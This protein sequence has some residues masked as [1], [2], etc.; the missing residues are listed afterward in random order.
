MGEPK[1]PNLVK[2]L[3]SK[4][5]IRLIPDIAIESGDRTVNCE[6]EFDVTVINESKKFASFCIEVLAIGADP[7]SNVKWYSLEPEVSAKKPPGDRTTFHVI[8]TKP[9]IP[10]YD[11]TIEL[12]LRVFSVEYPQVFTSQRINLIV[13]KARK[14]LKLHL[15]IQEFKVLPGEEVEIPVI[16]YNLSQKAT[17]VQLNI[18]GLDPEWIYRGTEQRLQIDAGDYQ[19]TSFWCQPQK[20]TQALSQAYNFTIEAKSDTSTRNPRE[21]GILEL[22]PL[23]NV[24][25][26]CKQ[27]LQRI[28]AIKV[29]GA[30]KQPKFATYE[31]EF[32]NN[33]NLPQQVNLQISAKDVQQCGLKIPEPLQLEPGEIKP[34]Y[35]VAKKRRPWW[36]LERRLLF[37][38]SPILTNPYT[39]EPDPQIRSNP[40]T[41]VLE[42]QI[43]PIIPFWLQLL[44][45]LLLLLLLW[46]LWYLNPQDYHKGSVHSVRLIGNSSLVVSGSSDQTIR[47]WQVDRSPWKLD[48]RRLKYE[49][50]IAK[51]TGKAVRVIHQSPRE[52]YVIASALE[53]GD[54][55][56]WDV[57]SKTD[58]R[59]IYQGTD[60][61][62]ALTFSKDSNYLFS[63]HGSGVV[64]GWNLEKP[65]NIKP[66]IARTGFTVYAMSISENL[67]NQ[68][69]TLVAIAGRYNKLS[70]WDWFNRRIYELEYFWEDGKEERKFSPIIGQHQYIDSLTIADPQSLMASSDNEGHISLWDMDKIRQC[71]NKSVTIFKN[72]DRSQPKTDG[73]GNLVIP[74]DCDDAIIDRWHQGHD[75]QPVRAVALS[76]NG[77]YLA[78][79]GDDGRVILWPLENRKRSPQY[80]DGKI[81]AEFPGV[82]L[83]SV[84]IKA[85]DDN[86]FIATG[87]DRNRVRLYRVQGI[88]ENDNANCQ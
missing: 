58:T 82:R 23:G 20:T 62:F 29:K 69:I 71:I 4:R 7:E 48:R 13:E 78:S 66:R 19:Q 57:L 44:G 45:L 28:P 8:I 80:P 22:L 24:E 81:I 32:A 63:G 49:G 64:R 74:L 26:M 31:L 46:L 34:M 3:V 60:R 55:K 68:P 83:N 84:D 16:A 86:L 41:K 15:P 11:A 77:C 17:E 61:V 30:K 87:D 18:S 38:V 33:S 25:F 27:K 52:D 14:A 85:L 40:S 36:W 54:I 50:F 51:E 10:I 43:L 76:Q 47:L 37:E 67:Q 65:A 42:L 88:N 79:G 70:L 53:S 73:F 6:N 39:A 9:P 56:L 2:A 75:K 5:E 59:S 72:S 35:L 1:V 12:T 21:Q